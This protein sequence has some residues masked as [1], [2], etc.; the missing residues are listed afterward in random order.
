MCLEDIYWTQRFLANKNKRTVSYV[1]CK[2]HKCPR[3]LCRAHRYGGTEGGQ[4]ARC[5]HRPGGTVSF[6]THLLLQEPQGPQAQ[7]PSKEE[8]LKMGMSVSISNAAMFRTSF[9]FGDHHCTWVLSW[10]TFHIFGFHHQ[11]LQTWHVFSE[12]MASLWRSLSPDT[13]RCL[14]K[15]LRSYLCFVGSHQSKCNVTEDS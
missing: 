12:D 3:S 15:G 6:V 10:R 4:W 8:V 2:V 11:G 14:V 5:T 1:I 7:F 9:L 13:W